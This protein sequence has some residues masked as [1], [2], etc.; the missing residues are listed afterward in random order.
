MGS[1][2][3]EDAIAP[4]LSAVETAPSERSSRPA[5]SAL[6]EGDPIGRYQLVARLGAGAMGVVWSAHDPQ[7]DRKV[8]IKLVHPNLARSP[9][10]SARLLR[11][12]RAMAKLSHRAVVT[13]HDAGEVE[14][15]L[16]L[17]MELV[18]GTNLGAMLRTRDP[19]S[20]EDWHHWLELM[21]EAG[22][23]LAAAHR[24]GVLHRDFKPDNVLVD[25][26][27]RV[28][29][30]DFGLATL[31]E[32]T[33]AAAMTA[34]W[35]PG[36]RFDLTTT[37][38]LLGTPAYMGPQQL[39]GEPVDARADQFSFCIATWEAL[40]GARPFEVGA[41]GL[42]AIHELLDK[43]AS[44]RPIPPPSSP[45][46]GEI[47]EILVRG[48]SPDPEARWP[49]MGALLFAL[50]R[51]HRRAPPIA[52]PRTSPRRH[53]AL[54]L[55]AAA[56]AGVVAIV[57]LRR[58]DHASP[59]PAPTVAP[60]PPPIPAPPA[61]AYPNVDVKRLFNVPSRTG[62]S[63]SPDGKRI[64]LGSNRLEVRGLET[65]DLWSAAL[66]VDADVSHMEL[67]EDSVRFALR[68]RE[69]VGLWRYLAGAEIESDQPLGGRWMGRTARGDL[70]FRLTTSVLAI[71]EGGSEVT[72]WPTRTR[73]D[74]TAIS[75]SGRRVAYLQATRFTGEI[76]VRDIDTGSEVSSGILEAPTAITWIDDRMIAYGT[77]T[78][79]QPRIHRAEVTAQGFTGASEVYGIDVGWFGELTSRNGVIY[80]IEMHPST[81]ARI[82]E[83]ARDRSA[84]HDLDNATGGAALAW[85][86]DDEFLTWNRDTHRIDRRSGLQVGVT[87][88]AV[89]GEP[90]NATLSDDTLIVTLRGNAGRSVVALSLSTGALLWRHSDKQTVAVRCASDRHPPCFAVRST[91]GSERLVTLDP[92]TGELGTTQITTGAFEDVAVSD[93]GKRLLLAAPAA[94]IPEIDLTGKVIA[95]YKSPLTNIRSV[96]YDPRGGI[97]V[98]GTLT[99]NNYQV[100]RINGKA[101]EL[102][103]QT[104]DDILSLVRPSKDGSRVLVLARVFA[105]EVWRIRPR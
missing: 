30:G 8:A 9:E 99:R 55:G 68:N 10:A 50:E 87:K 25:E 97:L 14:G 27:G 13:V 1:R 76:R 56:I 59:P 73:V 98:G 79:E 75:P 32:E 17:A 11:E 46:P 18:V 35:E 19:R 21:L 82:V 83:R 4:T 22:R 101:F 34:R 94:V 15:Q 58:P 66:P 7:L 47:A 53:L 77:G 70:T 61:V 41:Q 102:V 90:A 92:H 26:A 5:I 52:A 42:E 2:P 86:S 31:G 85:T 36:R 33:L 28:C 71:V 72:S 103:T 105:P 84:A 95:Q 96:A 43:L 67:G 29:V 39:R 60:S 24:A 74:V 78:L 23:G 3:D 20:L 64:A 54:G 16:F 62:M 69:N 81:R 51:V 63:V 93:D 80:A 12:A 57:V 44:E 6:R 100:G 37:G 91:D 65:A 88:L 104:D 49:D 45:V 38:A 40:Y 89:D 48:M